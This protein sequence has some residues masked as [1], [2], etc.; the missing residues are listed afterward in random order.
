MNFYLS[1]SLSTPQDKFP[2]SFGS[3]GKVWNKIVKVISPFVSLFSPFGCLLIGAERW[4]LTK[5]KE[6]WHKPSLFWATFEWT[7]RSPRIL[8]TWHLTHGSLRNNR[9]QWLRCVFYN[10]C[11]CWPQLF[12]HPSSLWRGHY[13]HLFHYGSGTILLIPK[14]TSRIT[15]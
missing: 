14:A 13:V 5:I 7:R 2:F 9:Y 12:F 11:Y 1:L 6:I 4:R 10:C 15:I 3:W 8:K